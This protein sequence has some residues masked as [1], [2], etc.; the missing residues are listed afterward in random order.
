MMNEDYVNA[1][2]LLQEAYDNS[3]EDLDLRAELNKCN[4][5]YIKTVLNNVEVLVNEYRI[6]DAIEE[7]KQALDILKENDELKN[8]LKEFF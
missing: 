5:I 2:Q 8:K 3:E 6:N 4:E 7:V 1:V